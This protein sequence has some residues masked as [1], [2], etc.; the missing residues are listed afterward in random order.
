MNAAFWHERW[1][2]NQ[3]GFHQDAVNPYLGRWLPALA[4]A[5]DEPIFVPLCGKSHDMYWLRQQGHP[6]V[7]VEL[8]PIATEAF[9][10]E[11]SLSP[12][13]ARRGTFEACEA[14]GIRVLCGDF[15]G[16]TRADLGPV[17]VV[18]DRAALIA[19][20]SDLR[21]RYVRH[22]ASLLEPDARMLL[23]TL[24]YPQA[25]MDG[26]P[27]SVPDAEIRALYSD[28]Y[29][30]ECAASEDVLAENARFRER[31][32]TALRENIYLVRGH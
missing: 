29:T 6:V 2:Q 31:G 23:I 30:V 4:L 32:L 25:Q 1:A 5:P 12:T 21:A 3:T 16:L 11:H 17:R 15:F 7:G 27:F 9:F 24:A 13:R 10:R 8:S 18:Y 20:P 19:L 14:E 22:L 28:R 26:P